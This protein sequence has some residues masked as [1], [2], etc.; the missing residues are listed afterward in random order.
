MPRNVRNFWLTMDVDGRG[1]TVETGPRGA[2][3]GFTLN[4]FMREKGEVAGVVMQVY[5]SVDVDG[6]LVLTARKANGEELQV[7]T[8]R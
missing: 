6:K 2:D 5:G 7:M 4:I 1:S 3:D 8:E